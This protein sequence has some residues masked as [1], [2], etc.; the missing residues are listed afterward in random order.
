MK[1]KIL[2]MRKIA[3]LCITLVT[4]LSCGDDVEFNT[5]GFQGN[6]NYN[7]WRATFYSA[8]FIDSSADNGGVIISAGNNNEKMMFKVSSANVGTYVLTPTSFSRADF[9]D[10]DELEYSTANPPDPSVSL[11]PEIGELKITEST[12]SYISGTFRF[13][14]FSADGL[15][16]VGFNEGL[17]YRVP[18]NGNSTSNPTLTC[19]Q[20]TTNLAT[21]AANFVEVQPGDS[22]YTP[23]CNAYKTALQQAITACGDQSGAFQAII[24]SLGDCS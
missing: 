2:T 13:I 10:F 11:Y 8:T 21:A 1:P 19:E 24:D 9:T 4:L 14:A 12:S 5:P 17:F 20:A 3:L 15:K 22:Q 6:K 16:S 23:R 7:L 18:I